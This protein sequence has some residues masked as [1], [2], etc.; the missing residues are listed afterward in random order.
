LSE[1]GWEI[2]QSLNSDGVF[3]LFLNKFL[4]KNNE[5][6]LLITSQL[7]ISDRLTMAKAN[8]KKPQQHKEFINTAV[9]GFTNPGFCCS[10]ERWIVIGYER[11]LIF[12][13]TRGNRG[14]LN[15]STNLENFYVD[16]L[17]HAQVRAA[18]VY[19]QYFKDRYLPRSPYQLAR[20]IALLPYEK[21]GIAHA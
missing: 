14:Q 1:K 3:M 21:R 7:N 4:L 13:A 12:D 15:N 19:I 2:I 20:V 6:L 18:I 11:Q 8:V 10:N 5:K 16:R 9:K 17:A